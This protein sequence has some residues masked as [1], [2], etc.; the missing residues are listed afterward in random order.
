MTDVGAKLLVSRLARNTSSVER[1][2]LVISQCD[3]LSDK[4]MQAIGREISSAKPG[5]KELSLGFY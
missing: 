1:L 3:H 2:S 5:L 4:G